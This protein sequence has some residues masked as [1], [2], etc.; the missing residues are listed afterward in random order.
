MLVMVHEL[1]GKELTN[2]SQDVLSDIERLNRSVLML[3]IMK[4]VGSF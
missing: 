1:S 2:I 4:G 3:R